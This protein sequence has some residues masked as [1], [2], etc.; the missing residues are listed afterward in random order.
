VVDCAALP[1][2]L[3]E[4]E[5]FGHVRGAFTGAA[6]ER[7][8]AIEVADGGT[9]FLDEIGELPL[10]VQPKLLR[11][12]ESRQ[13]RR[14]GETR[15]RNVDVRFVSATHRDLR[16]MVNRAAFR[17]DLFFRLAVITVNVPP[18][19]EHLD[20][21]PVLVEHLLPKG[22]EPFDESLL[23][24]LRAQPWLGNVRELRNFVE[25]VHALGTEE[26]LSMSGSL[27]HERA[28]GAP[29]TGV[30]KVSWET[31]PSV[32]GSYREVRDRWIERFERE[33]FSE[34]LRRYERNVAEAAREAGVDRTYVYRI[35][36]R[37]GL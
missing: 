36:R 26:A 10:S 33:Y 11:A 8:G 5:L 29:L 16:E 18:L 15:H 22:A 13:V 37:H 25:R 24:T 1:E 23:Q 20:D 9:V 32:A 31:M 17:E 6:V 2:T 12:L 19:R 35:I 7:E 27:P 28:E 30:T 14:I 3:V 4:A 21:I 34:L